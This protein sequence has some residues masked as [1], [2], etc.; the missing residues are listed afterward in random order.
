METNITDEL[1]EDN[2]KAKEV[3]LKLSACSCKSS[4]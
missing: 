3:Y 1:D 4:K 2:A